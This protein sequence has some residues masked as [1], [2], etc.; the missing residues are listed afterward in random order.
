MSPRAG[1]GSVLGAWIDLTDLSAEGHGCVTEERSI[2]ETNLEV[3]HQESSEVM[4]AAEE[5]A[6]DL[7]G[8]QS[9]LSVIL[10]ELSHDRAVQVVDAVIGR[11]SRRGRGQ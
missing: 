11:P 8:R 10:V 9:D 3:V 4:G 2:T 1:P 7:E 5:L 6:G